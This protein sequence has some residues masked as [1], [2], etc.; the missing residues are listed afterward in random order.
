MGQSKINKLELTWIGKY[1]ESLAL[2]P[3]LLIETPEY[4]YG[5]VETGTLPNGKP[6]YGNMLIHGDNLLAL[7][8]LEQDFAGQIKCIYIDP[9]YNIGAAVEDYDDN[10]ENSL[11]LSLMYSRLKIINKLLTKDGLLAVQIDDTNF[12]RLYLMLSEIF[13]EHNIKSIC[14]K[15]SEATGVKMASVN[16]AGSIAKIKEFIILAK[17]DGIKNLNLERIPKKFM[18]Q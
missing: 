18:G 10:I 8:A 16:K 1:D 7:R 3:R 5:E 13:G 15:M 14:V 6:W 12:A 11:W 4:S 17:K 2:E 9:P